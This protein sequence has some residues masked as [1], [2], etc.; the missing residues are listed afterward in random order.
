MIVMSRSSPGNAI[1]AS[2][3]LCVTMSSLP[4]TN[5]DR[6]P[7]AVA[8]TTTATAVAA[9][10]TSSDQARAVDVATQKVATGMIGS[11]QMLGRRALQAAGHVLTLFGV[12]R[13][14]VGEDAHQH[15]QHD[16]HRAEQAQRLLP[17][18]AVKEVRKGTASASRF[19]A[20]GIG[21]FAHW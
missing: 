2:T 15:K 8:T 16:D 3:N 6:P 13:Q 10:P 12:R 14:H 20:A 7:T 19:G 1:Q 18:Q 17:D 21:D 11:Q 4:P 5:P 9:K